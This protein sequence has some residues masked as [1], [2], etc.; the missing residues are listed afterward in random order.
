MVKYNILIPQLL[1]I[2][3]NVV[4]PILKYV[5]AKEIILKGHIFQEH[6]V[7]HG[8]AHGNVY[9]GRSRRRLYIHVPAS[10]LNEH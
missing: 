8:K 9:T 2:S 4:C 1:S 10:K 7:P 6:G 3:S 5:T